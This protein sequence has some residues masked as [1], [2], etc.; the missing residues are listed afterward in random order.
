L[1][2]L[3]SEGYTIVIVSNQ[4][5][6][7]LRP[8]KNGPK[9]MKETRYNQFKQKITAVFNALNLPITVYAATEKDR[10]RKPSIGMWEQFLTDQNLKYEDI[11]IE[12]SLFVGDAG[13]RLAGNFNGKLVKADFSCS[14]R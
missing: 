7:S 14:D 2:A 9:V 12:H 1:N 5:G 6:I 8:P 13:G 3:H 4:N 11:D 10:F